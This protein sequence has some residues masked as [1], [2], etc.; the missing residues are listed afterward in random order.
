MKS[1]KNVIDVSA[2]YFILEYFNNLKGK[3]S[4]LGIYVFFLKKQRK[5]KNIYVTKDLARI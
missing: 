3:S 4:I 2:K 5:K 1:C